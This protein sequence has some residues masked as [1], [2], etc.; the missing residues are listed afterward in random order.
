MR[1]IQN[2]TVEQNKNGS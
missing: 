1:S 2:A